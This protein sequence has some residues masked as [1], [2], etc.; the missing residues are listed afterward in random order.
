MRMRGSESTERSN[1]RAGM[2]R[3]RRSRTSDRMRGTRRLLTAFVVGVLVA[4]PSTL[5]A[6]DETGAL[7]AVRQI[8]DGMRRADPEMVRAVFAA[9]ARFAMVDAEES[10]ATVSVQ[11]VQGWLDAMGESEGA[12]DEQIYDVQVAVDGNMASVWAPYTFYLDGAI[13]HCG[14]DS[15]EMLHD[16]AGWRVTQISDTRR[17]TDCPDPLG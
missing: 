17:Q 1:V 9:D 6:Q 8:F 2:R 5:R 7:A 10:P 3:S 13:S 16:G 14:V 12:W 11:S 15:I 4:A